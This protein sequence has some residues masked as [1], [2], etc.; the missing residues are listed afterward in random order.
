MHPK[1]ILESTENSASVFYR[2]DHRFTK[3][4]TRINGAYLI[5]LRVERASTLTEQR[6]ASMPYFTPSLL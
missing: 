3:V 1:A 2:T 4:E 5:A 6:L